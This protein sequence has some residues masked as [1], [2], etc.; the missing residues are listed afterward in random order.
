METLMDLLL[1]LPRAN[2]LQE[3][4]TLGRRSRKERHTSYPKDYS[5]SKAITIRRESH[6]KRQGWESS[7][8]TELRDRQKQSSCRTLDCHSHFPPSIPVF[9]LQ[10]HAERNPDAFIISRQ[11]RCISLSLSLSHFYGIL[12]KI[13]TIF[14]HDFHI[15]EFAVKRGT[16]VASQ[17][18]M[19]QSLTFL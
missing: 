11:R 15:N 14:T 5:N 13:K 16:A 4:H 17:C 18:D 6:Q 10:F 8:K 7:E 3:I 19:I 9:H 2:T 12:M 1:V